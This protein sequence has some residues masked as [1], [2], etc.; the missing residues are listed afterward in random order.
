MWFQNNFM[1]N[2]KIKTADNFS[3][4]ATFVKVE[5]STKIIIF[6]HG[7]T[8][9][10]DDEGI[11]VRAEKELNQSGFSTLRFDFRAHGKSQGDSIADFTISNEIKDLEAVFN[12]IKNH[13]FNWIGLA[14][15]SFGGGIAA[16]YAG[17]YPKQIQS[18]FLAN[19]V[20]N[21]EKEFLN[22]TTP[23][24]K[25]HFRNVFERI[26][27]DGYIVIGSRKFK[28]GRKVFEEM[29]KFY[30]CDSLK[31]YQ[32]KLMIVHGDKD[33]KV[34]YENVVKCFETLPNREKEIKILTGSEHGFHEEPYESQT[35]RM[36]V[37]FFLSS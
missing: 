8:V 2:I 1:N 21:Y 28:V 6:A 23:W 22:P 19:P 11:F 12:F 32:G 3:L 31:N 7:M 26:D 30:P 15:V 37:D 18:L 13:G 33:S 35:V 29:K 17:K 4:D 16:L 24:A 5:K 10:R 36:I 20:L 34:A 14:G 9:D 27:K 25:E